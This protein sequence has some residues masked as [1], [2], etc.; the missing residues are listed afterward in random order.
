MPRCK[1]KGK[2]K[3]KEEM[4]DMQ[5]LLTIFEKKNET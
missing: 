5:D 2:I 3:R 4:I 1:S